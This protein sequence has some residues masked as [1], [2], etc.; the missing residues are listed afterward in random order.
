MTR[1]RLLTA[2]IVLTMLTT[3]HAAQPLK[4]YILAG[5]SNMVGM[6]GANTLEHIKMTPDTAPADCTVIG[7]GEG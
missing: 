2:G 6:A 1:T 7:P 4:V 5:Q 3:A